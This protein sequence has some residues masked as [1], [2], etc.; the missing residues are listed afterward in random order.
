MTTQKYPIG[1]RFLTRGRHSRLC[2]VVD[3]LTTTNIAGKI[4]KT[5]Y[6]TTHVLLGQVVTDNDVTQTS[7]DMGTPFAA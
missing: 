6:V 4:V 5:R 1:Y 2:T 3:Y 7:I